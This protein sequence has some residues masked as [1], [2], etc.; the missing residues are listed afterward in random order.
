VQFSFLLLHMP[1]VSRMLPAAEMTLSAAD[2]NIVRIQL[3]PSL[4]QLATVPFHK[5]KETGKHKQ[6]D[7]LLSRLHNFSLLGPTHPLKGDAHLQ[8]PASH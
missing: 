3:I 5:Y 1:T 4:F 2:F 6:S 8:L 7:C